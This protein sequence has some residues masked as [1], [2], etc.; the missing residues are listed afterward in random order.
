MYGEKRL[1]DRA[2]IYQELSEGANTVPPE[3]RLATTAD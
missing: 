3:M 2:I 1:P